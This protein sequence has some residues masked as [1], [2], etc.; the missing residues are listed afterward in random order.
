MTADPGV[1]SSISVRSHVTFVETDHEIISMAT[2]IQEGLLSAT[3]ESMCTKL[4]QACPEK[5]WLGELTVLT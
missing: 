4:S 5:V 3:R 1:T 2:L